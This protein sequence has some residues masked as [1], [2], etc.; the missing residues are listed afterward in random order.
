[1]FNNSTTRREFLKAATSVSAAVAL[2]PSTAL[3]NT[4]AA[5]PNILYLHSHDSGRYLRPYGYNV[6]TPNLMRIAER[7]TIFR[8]MFCAAPTCSASRAALLTGQSSHASGMNGLAHRG[9]KLHDYKQHLLHTLREEK[10]YYT[11]LA[12]LQHIAVNPNVIGYDKILPGTHRLAADVA[13]HTEEFLRNTPKQPFFLDCGFFE[14]HRE[15]PAPTDNPNYI[16][17]PMPLPDTLPTRIDMAGFH[18]S[19]RNMDKAIGRILDALEANGLRENTLIISTTDH[20]IAFP[21]M[22]ANLTDDGIGVSFIMSGPGEFS[23]PEVCDALL[24]QVDVFPTLCEYLGISKPTW[25]TGT[26]FLSVVR[27]EKQEVNEA[28]FSEV[29]YHSAYEPKRCVRTNRFK[30]QRRY[31]G[32]SAYV[33]SNCDGGLSKSYWLSEGWQ[34]KPLLHVEELY[35]LVFDPA[36]RNNLADDPSCVDTLKAMRNRLDTWMHATDDPLLKGP[37]PLPAGG[38]TSPVI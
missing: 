31:D 20:G 10:G 16:L 36:E 1:V 13:T 21:T 17:P 14:T 27:G 19:A 7:G 30:Y 5:L 18:Q 11:V 32:R 38:Y 24:S 28:I 6:P 2:R 4:I 34:G 9:W 33:I 37:V 25:L 8:K 22:K 29:T 26:S 12:G 35:D 23:K 3:G 15:Y